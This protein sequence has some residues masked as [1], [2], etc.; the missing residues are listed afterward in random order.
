MEKQ[1]IGQFL[2]ALRR[3]NGYTQQDV[4]EKLGVSNKTVSCWE[5]DSYSPDISLIPAIA[6]LYDVT[7]D[8]ILRAKRAPVQSSEQPKNEAE[9]EKTKSGAGKAEK[10]ASAIFDN[11]LARYDNTHKIAVA[12]LLFAATIGIIIATVTEQATRVRLWA[13]AIAAPILSVCIFLLLIVN[14]R[15]NFALSDDERAFAIKKR[16][17]RRKNR[18]LAILIVALASFLPCA[19]YLGYNFKYYMFG[20]AF[21]VIAA[22]ALILINLVRRLRKPEYFTPFPTK[23]KKLLLTV[24]TVLFAVALVSTV[25]YRSHLLVDMPF[26]DEFDEK[27]VVCKDID[28][29]EELLGRRTLPD[30]YEE[31]SSKETGNRQTVIYSVSA[32]DFNEEDLAAYHSY[33]VISENGGQTYKIYVL[34]DALNIEYSHIDPESEEINTD[35]RRIVVY[36]ENYRAS[37]LVSNNDGTYELHTVLHM[38]YEQN[39]SHARDSLDYSVLFFGA[40]AAAITL[41]IFGAVYL[42]V[43]ISVKKRNKS[44]DGSRRAEDNL[45][46]PAS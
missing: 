44:D 42:T 18:A 46:S 45:A 3:S 40:I 13:F 41:S 27:V 29:L 30:C 24:Y 31:I 43:L 1:T 21:A 16:I 22:M 9:A 12:C 33:S 15:L 37:Y 5:R 2:S 35:T 39:Y 19:I 23:A 20:V 7:C 17:Y 11:M 32:A 34:Y 36:N 6:E 14:F 26:Y 38:Y 10:E 28:E 25:F 4:A 8:E